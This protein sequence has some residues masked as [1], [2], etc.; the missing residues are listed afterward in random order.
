[1][2]QANRDSCKTRHNTTK[3]T[4]SLPILNLFKETLAPPAQTNSTY[5]CVRPTDRCEL[6]KDEKKPA[7]MSADDT[8]DTHTHPHVPPTPEPAVPRSSRAAGCDGCARW[9]AVR[10]RRHAVREVVVTAAASA[11]AE[12]TSLDRRHYDSRASRATHSERLN[13]SHVQHRLL[14][15]LNS[16]NTLLIKVLSADCTA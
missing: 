16:S 8:A 13:Q 15:S 4:T 14:I 6:H 9:C 12:R 5:N 11:D 1:M 7:V 3:A 10:A 2:L